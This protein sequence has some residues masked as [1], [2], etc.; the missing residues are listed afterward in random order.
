MENLSYSEKPKDI[1]LS[2]KSPMETTLAKNDTSR[3]TNVELVVQAKESEETLPAGDQMNKVHLDSPNGESNPVAKEETNA[4]HEDSLVSTTANAKDNID[5]ESKSS[6]NEE[7]L[8]ERKET[9]PRKISTDDAENATD[10]ERRTLTENGIYNDSNNP[11]LN[12]SPAAAKILS[13]GNSTVNMNLHFSK[14][15]LNEPNFHFVF[16]QTK[17]MS[18]GL[19]RI[20]HT[21]IV[22]GCTTS[23]VSPTSASQPP[24]LSNATR[25][26]PLRRGK[27]TVEEEA[28]VARVIQDFNSGFL[29]APAG[30][31]LRSYLSEKLQCDPMRITKKFTGEACIGKRVFHPAVRSAGN[32]SA[33]DKAQAEL[34][35]LERRWRKR[36]ELQQRESAKKAAASAAAVNASPQ[37]GR[38]HFVQGVPVALLGAPVIQPNVV[39]Q[40]ASW[41]DRANAI[42]KG[43]KIEGGTI[44]GSDSSSNGKNTFDSPSSNE[45]ENQ[46]REVQRLI[47]EGPIIQQTA[48][49]LP[50]LLTYDGSDGPSVRNGVSNSSNQSVPSGRADKRPRRTSLSGEEAAEALLGFSRSVPASAAAGQD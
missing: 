38:G 13:N 23:N 25:T 32:A 21:D 7:A 43:A 5:S 40:T 6:T 18:P 49:G 45:I 46:M 35:A 48:A 36:L 34:D 29:N 16:F 2:S 17:I 31:T 42:L 22:N 3:G 4:I 15:S 44:S 11:I 1:E 14:V 19:P 26:K 24:P 8:R 20:I 39:T 9:E 27:W 37:T 50:Q 33:I 28:Y 10:K 47:Y 41:L 12:L 30:T